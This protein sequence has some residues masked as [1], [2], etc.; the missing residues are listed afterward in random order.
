MKR[1]KVNK[2]IKQMGS[3]LG[4]TFNMATK[5]LKKSGRLVGLNAMSKSAKKDK[6]VKGAVLGGIVGLAVGFPIAG[7]VVGGVYEDQKN[8]KR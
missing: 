1:N 8:K 3:A 5:G 4:D 2:G 7:A 6:V